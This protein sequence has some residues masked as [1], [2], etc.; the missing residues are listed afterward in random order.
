MEALLDEGFYEFGSCGRVWTKAEILLLMA[1]EE[2]HEPL[3]IE[4]FRVRR[5]CADAALV[6]YR[7]VGSSRSS[8][9][10][11]F[12][13]HH[14]SGWQMVFHQGTLVPDDSVPCN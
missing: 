6:S 8:L 2:N 11:S 14:S 9:R 5:I 10:S 7:A 1:N 3:A 4:E 12:W 13:K